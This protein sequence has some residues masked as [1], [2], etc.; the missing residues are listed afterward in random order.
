MRRQ[1]TECKKIFAK[2]ILEKEVVSSRCQW[3][4]PIILAIQEAKIRRI[5]VESQPRQIDQKTRS[6]KTPISLS[7]SFSLS[8]SLS[9]SLSHTHTH[10]H[11]HTHKGLEEWLLPA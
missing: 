5:T 10:T 4:M 6:Q 7:L 8:L 3:L 11:T 2:D 1:T 9:L